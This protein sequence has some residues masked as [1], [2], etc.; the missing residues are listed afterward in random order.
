MGQVLARILMESVVGKTVDMDVFSVVGDQVNIST[1]N[2]TYNATTTN[3]DGESERK[4]Y[5][6]GYTVIISKL[7]NII[8]TLNKNTS[9]IQDVKNMVIDTA[10]TLSNMVQTIDTLVKEVAHLKLKVQSVHGKQDTVIA[11]TTNFHTGK[12]SDSGLLQ[13]GSGIYTRQV[14]SIVP[15]CII[16]PCWYK[17][18]GNADM[19]A[20]MKYLKGLCDCVFPRLDPRVNSKL[21]TMLSRHID[22]HEDNSLVGDNMMMVLSGDNNVTMAENRMAVIKCMKLLG[23]KYAFMLPSTLSKMLSRVDSIREGTVVFGTVA[24]PKTVMYAGQ[25][26]DIVSLCCEPM[27]Y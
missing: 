17:H 7:L 2:S 6:V 20:T 27:E 23:T 8:N 13:T 5:A 24:D 25:G 19:G 11:L 14:G 21:G 18:V 1:L 26:Y 12:S 3:N 4:D 10:H 15:A 22:S 9:D 16:G